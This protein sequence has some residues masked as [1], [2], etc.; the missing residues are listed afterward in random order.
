MGVWEVE[1]EELWEV[2]TEMVS[3][4]S[5]TTA[6]LRTSTHLKGDKQRNTPLTH[7]SDTVYHMHNE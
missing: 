4:I 1:V 6:F 3:S 2:F 7:H 5:P